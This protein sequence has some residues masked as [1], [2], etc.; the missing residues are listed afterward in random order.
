M[1]CASGERGGAPNGG[2]TLHQALMAM[3]YSAGKEIYK[4]QNI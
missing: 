1:E 4:C 3:A 2:G